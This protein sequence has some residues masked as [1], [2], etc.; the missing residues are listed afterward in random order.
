MRRP[1][2][3]GWPRP[4]L[5]LFPSTHTSPH[6]LVNHSLAM[7]AHCGTARRSP[8]SGA[9]SRP[10]ARPARC[11]Q[12]AHRGAAGALSPPPVAVTLSR[13]P[14]PGLAGVASTS[15]GEPA[16]DS[17]P[18]RDGVASGGGALPSPPVRRRAA[19]RPPEGGRRVGR[20]TSPEED[21]IF[22]SSECEE[23][24]R[25]QLRLLFHPM[26]LNRSLSFPPTMSLLRTPAASLRPC[27]APA[28]RPPP[29]AP[30][31]A[32]PAP[33]RAVRLAPPRAG[34]GA[35]GDDPYEVSVCLGK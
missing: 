13:R 34:A 20:A 9:R 17:S 29:L 15:R 11:P 4:T 16:A 6:S 21:M 1:R 25:T 14:L 33:R 18:T 23:K 19:A 28:A 27:R 10:P 22:C 30:R 31:R 24:K 5:L 3:R 32:A 12:H 26:H 7:R 8:G 35:G 2:A